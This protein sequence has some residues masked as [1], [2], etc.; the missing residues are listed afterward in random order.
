MILDTDPVT[1]GTQNLSFGRPG[2]PLWHP[3]GPGADPGAPGSRRKDTLGSRLGFLSILGGF[4]D[5]FLR[6]FWETWT[7]LSVFVMLVSRSHFVLILGSDSGCLGLQKQ[8]FG[9]RGVA[10]TNFS[11][12]LEFCCFEGPFLMFLGGLRTNFH[13][14]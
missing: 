4:R 3:G 14:F 6:A 10:K 13:D 8:A 9:V 1:F 11:Q 7:K 5:P 2:A 12:K